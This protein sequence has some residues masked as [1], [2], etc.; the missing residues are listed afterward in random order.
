MMYFRFMWIVKRWQIPLLDGS[1]QEWVEAIRGAGLC[2]AEDV[3]G[4]N[5]EKMA[6][7]IDE[8]V[9]LRNDDCFVAAFPSSQIHI[10]YGIDFP[11]V[12]L[13]PSPWITNCLSIWLI[14]SFFLYNHHCRL[15]FPIFLSLWCCVS[16]N[17]V[18]NGI[19][20]LQNWSEVGSSWP[21]FPS[22]YVMIW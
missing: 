1:A 9:Y 17:S 22:T 11:K 16:L 4:Q 2:A 13:M 19:L 20:L 5:L 15:F 14:H 8:P 10:T 12:C 3:S 18:A 6:P 21:F 7:K